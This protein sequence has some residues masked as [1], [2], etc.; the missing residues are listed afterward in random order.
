MNEQII[1]PI[2]PADLTAIRRL[3]EEYAASLN[4]DLCFQ[5]FAAEL[6]GLPGA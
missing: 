4:V 3:F 5:N 1:Q 2:S 6:A